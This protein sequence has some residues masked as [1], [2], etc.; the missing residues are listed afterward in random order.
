MTVND[1]GVPTYIG[2]DFLAKSHGLQGF[3][4]FCASRY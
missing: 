1:G 2:I 4:Q 3:V